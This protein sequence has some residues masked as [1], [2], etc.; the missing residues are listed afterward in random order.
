MIVL[1]KIIDY[2]TIEN[3]EI[4]SLGRDRKIYLYT[5][6]RLASRFIYQLS[7]AEFC[8]GTIPEFLYDMENRKPA[9]IV[10]NEKDGRYDHLPQW[11]EPVYTMIES[12]Y[13]M[14]SDKNGYFIFKLDR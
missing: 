9:I 12:E 14:I 6:R 1:G 11:Y 13:R 8:P 7:G 5:E 2:N 3:D 10:I 4:I